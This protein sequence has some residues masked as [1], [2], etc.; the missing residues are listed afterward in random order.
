MGGEGSDAHERV[1]APERAAFRPP[2]G[3]AQRVGQHAVA[4]PEL[5]QPGKG[6]LRR[7]ADRQALEDAEARMRLHDPHEAQDRRPRHQAVGVERQHQLGVAAGAELLQVAGLVAGIVA[8]P[9]ILDPLR[10]R[11]G[12]PGAPG[13]DPLLLG[14]DDG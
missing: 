6:A 7:R 9:A 5:E 14:P 8:A 12:Q 1:V 2:P 4:H 11:A 10:L 13:R 3:R